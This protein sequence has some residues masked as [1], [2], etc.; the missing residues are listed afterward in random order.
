MKTKKADKRSRS[1]ST[2]RERVGAK[3]GSLNPIFAKGKAESRMPQTQLM[4]D[5]DAQA[6]F[7]SYQGRFS[8]CGFQCADSKN[9]TSFIDFI[10]TLPKNQQNIIIIMR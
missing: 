1:R 2:G 3:S 10:K 5:I 4:P 8:S 7:Q 9:Q 6:L